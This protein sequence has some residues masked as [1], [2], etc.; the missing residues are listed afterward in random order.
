MAGFPLPKFPSTCV[1]HGKPGH[2]RVECKKG[3]FQKG[4]SQKGNVPGLCVK[5]K[6][7]NNWANQCRS[8]F[9]KDDSLLSGNGLKV[10]SQPRQ[11]REPNPVQTPQMS[12]QLLPPATMV[13]ITCR[14]MES[15]PATQRNTALDV[16]SG[17]DIIVTPGETPAIISTGIFGLLPQGTVGLLLGRLGLTS[18]EVQ[19]HSGVTDSNYKGELKAMV[20][21]TLP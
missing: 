10:S 16:S 4:N 21:T 1:N 6:K 14:V 13:R 5:C 17:Q 9:H 2:T 18:W 11:T 19:V 8:K 7:G 15:S 20:S 3:N 12:P